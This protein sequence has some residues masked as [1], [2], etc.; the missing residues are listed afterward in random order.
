MDLYL[1]VKSALHTKLSTNLNPYIKLTLHTN[2]I[3]M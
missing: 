3:Y 1:Y 2:L